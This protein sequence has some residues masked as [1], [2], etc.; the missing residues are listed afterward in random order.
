M[1]MPP[2]G[3]TEPVTSSG[4]VLVVIGNLSL[5]VAPRASGF[6]LGNRRVSRWNCFSSLHADFHMNGIFD[7]RDT[8]C[9]LVRLMDRLALSVNRLP[10]QLKSSTHTWLHYIYSAP[11]Y[12]LIGLLLLPTIPS[13]VMGDMTAYTVCWLTVYMSTSRDLAIYVCTVFPLGLCRFLA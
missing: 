13:L 9:G 3:N 1:L 5:F 7:R 12:L 2:R 8:P 11:Q 10:W 4:I 6:A